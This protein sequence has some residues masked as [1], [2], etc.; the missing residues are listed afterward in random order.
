MT[1]ALPLPDDAGGTRVLAHRLRGTGELD[2]G[3]VRQRPRGQI[4]TSGGRRHRYGGQVVRVRHDVVKERPRSA[5]AGER[6]LGWLTAELATIGGRKTVVGAFARGRQRS[7]VEPMRRAVGG[8][9]NDRG[10]TEP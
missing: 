8:Q 7:G 10:G 2:P 4:E 1:H 9:E 5:E 6:F 3:P